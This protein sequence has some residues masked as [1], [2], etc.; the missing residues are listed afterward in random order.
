[1]FETIMKTIIEICEYE[2]ITQWNYQVSNFGQQCIQL[3][4]A[5][6]PP[7]DALLSSI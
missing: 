1:M 2:D 5:T 6:R 3:S 4:G 7:I